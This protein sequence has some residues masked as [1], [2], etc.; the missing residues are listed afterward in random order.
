MAIDHVNKRNGSI[1]PYLASSEF[2]DCDLEVSRV[3][4]SNEY[5][6]SEV[7][8][9]WLPSF[10]LGEN[11][12]GDSSVLNSKNNDDNEE[13]ED[14]TSCTLNPLAS[15]GSM[16]QDDD[17]FSCDPC[18]IGDNATTQTCSR[19][20]LS[21]RLSNCTELQICSEAMDSENDIFVSFIPSYVESVN[22]LLSYLVDVIHRDYILILYAADDVG[23]KLFRDRI[24][25]ENKAQSSRRPV[26][27]IESFAFDSTEESIMQAFK[28]AVFSRFTTVILIPALEYDFELFSKAVNY[29][30]MNDSAYLWIVVDRMMGT[31]CQTSLPLL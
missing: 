2:E 12:E 30:Y 24:L 28:S 25:S 13:D 14:E 19:I 6:A 9:T 17:Q 21:D 20:S 31:F 26:L 8:E 4:V 16:I 10:L 3:M 5:N 22:P 11:G 29:A 18:Y 27:T 23:A 1:V 7:K 15:I